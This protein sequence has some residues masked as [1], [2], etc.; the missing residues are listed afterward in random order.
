M[1]SH[2]KKEKPAREM[3]KGSLSL[4]L[5]L[6]RIS[7]FLPVPQGPLQVFTHSLPGSFPFLFP[8]LPLSPQSGIQ[9]V[10]HRL[11]FLQPRSSW[12][13]LPPGASGRLPGCISPSALLER[14]PGGS[15]GDS[16]RWEWCPCSS[17]SVQLGARQDLWDSLGPLVRDS[18]LLSAGWEGGGVSH[19]S[20]LPL[21][22]QLSLQ[23]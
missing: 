13:S 3:G 10:S 14:P 22:S 12:P 18:R 15:G 1:L 21:S 19:L 7:S 2:R 8:H 4:W 6:W 20:Q 17:G 9:Q 5:G 23:N 11:L 16:P